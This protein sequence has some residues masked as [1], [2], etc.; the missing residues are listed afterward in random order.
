MVK[1]KQE[2]KQTE[3]SNDYLIV[4]RVNKANVEINSPDSLNI[5]MNVY[6]LFN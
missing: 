5:V 4:N 1:K 3:I 6:Q 2:I